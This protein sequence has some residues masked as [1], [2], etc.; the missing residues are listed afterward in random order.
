M[1]ETTCTCTQR[2]F[3]TVLWS[4]FEI[5]GTYLKKIEETRAIG[6]NNASGGEKTRNCSGS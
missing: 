6:E 4:H 2:V 5:F 1:T 3:V